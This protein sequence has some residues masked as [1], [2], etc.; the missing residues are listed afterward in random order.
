MTPQEIIQRAIA[1]TRA[2]NADLIAEMPHEATS[3]A[4]LILQ[5]AHG[6]PREFAQACVNAIGE[7]SCLEAHTAIQKYLKEWKEAA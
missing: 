2:D 4:Q 3:P 7:I 5:T 6:T 1:E